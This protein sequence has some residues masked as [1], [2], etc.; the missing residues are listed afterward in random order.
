[1]RFY[2][3]KCGGE[4]DVKKRKCTRCKKKWNP[5]WFRLDPSSIRPMRIAEISHT[6]PGDKVMRVDRRVPQ[7]KLAWI[8]RVPGANI[9]P[10]ILPNWPRW[11]R[12]LA[13]VV[14]VAAAIAAYILLRK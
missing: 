9:L 12:I 13:T 2:H 11:A 14:F 6:K 7:G 4:I 3:T 5:I 8:S 10:S 1:M